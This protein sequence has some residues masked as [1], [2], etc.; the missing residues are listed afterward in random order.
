MGGGDKPLLQLGGRS[1]LDHVQERLAP[2]CE[3]LILSANGEAR[4]FAELS[5]TVVPDTLP[6]YLGP[7]AGI[8][9]ALEWTAAHRPNIEWVASVPG[10]T[11]FLPVDLIQRLHA[12]REASGKALAC[13]ASAGRSH[14]AAGL[15]PVRLRHDL[16]HALGEDV[17]SIRHWA[18]P[19]GLAVVAWAV[20]PLDPFLNINTP[21]DLA[22]AGALLEEFGRR[23]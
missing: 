14:F 3:H 19:H 20:E 7:L 10:D 8:L 22:E 6:G 2:Q 17:R 11:P 12:A 9:T 23:P 18:E 13:A 4:R 5:L 15:W 1:L 16:N 21:E